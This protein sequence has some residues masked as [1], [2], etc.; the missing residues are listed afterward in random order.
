MERPGSRLLDWLLVAPG[1][2]FFLF[3]FFA[4]LQD[5]LQKPLLIIVLVARDCLGNIPGS[6]LAEASRRNF[7]IQ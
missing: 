3:F 4:N 2:R 1:W 7:E 6:E 5:L